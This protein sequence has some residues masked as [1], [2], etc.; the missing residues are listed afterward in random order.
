MLSC[1]H[2]TLSTPQYP[3]YPLV[4][5]C[6]AVPSIPSLP[7]EESGTGHC[8]ATS[9]P[10]LAHICAGTGPH[11]RRDWPTSAPGLAARIFRAGGAALRGALQHLRGTERSTHVL[12]GTREIK[13]T[14]SGAIGPRGR[15]ARGW[16][17]AR[18]LLRCV[19]RVHVRLAGAE[20]EDRDL[21]RRGVARQP[22]RTSPPRNA[23]ATQSSRG[24]VPLRGGAVSGYCGMRHARVHQLSSA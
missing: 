19:L 4:P 1:T 7:F 17:L 13:G 3:S 18:R 20:D 2:G 12:Q 8:A 21:P 6:P 14:C 5:Y 15:H 16:D 24:T 9:A 10:G 11:L 22:R 23:A